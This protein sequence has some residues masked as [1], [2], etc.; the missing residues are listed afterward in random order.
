MRR[1]PAILAME[2]E[3]YHVWDLEVPKWN[4]KSDFQRAFQAMK[5][6]FDNFSSTPVELINPRQISDGSYIYDVSI[7]SRFEDLND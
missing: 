7:P 5:I 3:I 4:G 2:E 1:V 6:A